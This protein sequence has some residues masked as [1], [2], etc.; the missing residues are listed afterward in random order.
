M[1]EGKG[2]VKLPHPVTIQDEYLAEILKVQREILAEL[3]QK[4]TVGIPDS[5][6]VKEPIK[7]RG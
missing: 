7:R 5:T 1:A 6:H 3:R 4:V 2:E